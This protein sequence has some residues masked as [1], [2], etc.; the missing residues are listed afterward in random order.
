MVISLKNLLEYNKENILNGVDFKIGIVVFEWNEYII[1][2]LLDGVKIIFLE[3][4]VKEENII[5]FVVLG[6]FELF[7]GV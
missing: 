2:R 1:F 6:V 3:V 4:G 5:V 7:L